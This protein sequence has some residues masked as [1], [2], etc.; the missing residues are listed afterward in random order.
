MLTIKIGNENLVW[1]DQDKEYSCI[2]NKVKLFIA[3]DFEDNSTWVWEIIRYD[4]A[5]EGGQQSIEQIGFDR[6]QTAAN[7]LH[8]F[9]VALGAMKE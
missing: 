9:L 8:L 6:A 3:R 5:F 1:N 4:D 7:N 2:F